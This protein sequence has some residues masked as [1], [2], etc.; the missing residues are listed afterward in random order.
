MW[1]RPH[2]GGQFPPT[3]TCRTSLSTQRHRLSYNN[4][5]RSLASYNKCHQLPLL[6]TV[7]VP[8]RRHSAG[9]AEL[10]AVGRWVGWWWWQRWWR[11]GHLLAGGA[12][13][14][15]EVKPLWWWIDRW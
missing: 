10:T 9:G 8:K 15:V 2:I 5:H 4:Y 1:G 13:A 7:V 12:V 11:V 14:V 3:I 6:V